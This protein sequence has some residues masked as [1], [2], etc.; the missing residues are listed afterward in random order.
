[1][2]YFQCSHRPQL[3]HTPFVMQLG[4]F[5]SFEK[6]DAGRKGAG[7]SGAASSGCGC[8]ALR[9]SSAMALTTGGTC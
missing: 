3:L 5:T 1:M 4:W 7:A 9:S 2:D 6:N 8:A